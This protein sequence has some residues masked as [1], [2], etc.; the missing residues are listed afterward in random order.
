MKTLKKWLLPWPHRT[1]RWKAPDCPVPPDYLVEPTGLS[2]AGARDRAST[3]LS[4]AQGQTIQC[5]TDCPVGKPDYPVRQKQPRVL[6]SPNPKLDQ[7]FSNLHQTLHRPS[8]HYSKAIPKRSTE[9]DPGD[10][11]N[12]RSCEEG[13]IWARKG[14]TQEWLARGNLAGLR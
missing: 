1:L 8:W 3:G 2:G 9:K 6:E 14:K 12:F 13:N 5:A 7:I 4:G 11:R 10:S